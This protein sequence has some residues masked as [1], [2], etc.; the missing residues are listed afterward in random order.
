MPTEIL[1]ALYDGGAGA[2][3]ED[4]WSAIEQSPFGAGAFIWD[5]ADEGIV[6]SDR[7]GQIDV[8]STFAPDGIVGPH[9]EKEGS[10]YTLRD[11]W[12]PVQ[13]TRSIA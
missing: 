2:G 13:I 1:H 10:Y 8:F 6:R 7:N 9:F 3:L 5:F 11:V 4:Y 12:S